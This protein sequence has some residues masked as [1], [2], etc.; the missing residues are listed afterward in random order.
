MLADTEWQFQWIRFVNI[1]PLKLIK[2]TLVHVTGW[3]WFG[4]ARCL[5]EFVLR[6]ISNETR[7]YEALWCWSVPPLPTAI[8]WQRNKID[9][10]QEAGWNWC[11]FTPCLLWTCRHPITPWSGTSSIPALR[12][13]RQ[14]RLWFRTTSVLWRCMFHTQRICQ[15]PP[16]PPRFNSFAEENG[17]S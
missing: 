3:F 4:R 7:L 13:E 17:G 6:Q 14:G 15:Q 11:T 1:L 12:E 5:L 8:C 10:T 16:V 9:S 2:I